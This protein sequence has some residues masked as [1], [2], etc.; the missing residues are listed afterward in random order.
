MLFYAVYDKQKAISNYSPEAYGEDVQ[1]RV[2]GAQKA[3]S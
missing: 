2:D 1:Y 3:A